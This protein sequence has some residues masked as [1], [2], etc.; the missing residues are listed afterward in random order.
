[1]F[2]KSNFKMV[3]GLTVIGGIAATTL[4]FVCSLDLTSYITYP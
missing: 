2:T 3:F 4:M 1:M